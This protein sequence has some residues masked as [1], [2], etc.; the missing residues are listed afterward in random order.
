MALTLPCGQL[1]I[2]NSRWSPP[3]AKPENMTIAFV[4]PEHA[5]MDLF[6][7]Y[8]ESLRLNRKL[9]RVVIDEPHPTLQHEDFRECFSKLQP[10]IAAGVFSPFTRINQLM[11]YSKAEVPFFLSAATCPPCLMASLLKS[12]AI[13]NCYTIRAPTDR[14]EILYN[15]NISKTDDQA[16]KVLVDV[17]QARLELESSS[18]SFRCLVYSRSKILGQNSAS[19]SSPK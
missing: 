8:I 4:S 18:P 10:L 7:K 5:Q 13:R 17:V 19:T 14:P 3:P 1:H 11:V 6:L 12:L 2:Q 9:A 15:V 16:Q